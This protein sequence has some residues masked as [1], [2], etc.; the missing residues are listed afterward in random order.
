MKEVE[1]AK[2]AKKKKE[3]KKRERREKDEGRGQEEEGSQDSKSQTSKLKSKGERA[4]IMRILHAT[5]ASDN[6]MI[7][8]C[9]ARLCWPNMRADLH[10][11]YQ[12]CQLGQQVQT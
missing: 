9:K 12:E 7:R 3:E 5:H 4:K 11:L 2:A 8:Q 10:K 1:K 6:T